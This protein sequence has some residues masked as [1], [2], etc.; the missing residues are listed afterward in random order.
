L[1]ISLIQ[2]FRTHWDSIVKAFQSDG[3]IGGIKR[4]GVV[5]LD[6]I[7]MPIQQLLELLSNIPGLGDLASAGATKIG[8]IRQSLDLIPAPEQKQSEN[9]QNIGVN[10]NIGI[11]IN[12]RNNNV[13]NITSDF[14]G[15]GITPKVTTTQGGF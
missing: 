11:N 7:L 15:G 3:I 6:A 12:D 1:I 2:S 14:G 9:M 4:I 10:G 5:I 8:E 13:G